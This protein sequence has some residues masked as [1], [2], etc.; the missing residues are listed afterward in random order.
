[1]LSYCCDWVLLVYWH[2]DWLISFSVLSAAWLVWLIFQFFV[3]WKDMMEWMQKAE[4]LLDADTSVSNDHATIKAQIIKHRVRSHE[5]LKN[6]WERWHLILCNFSTAI[7]PT[8]YVSPKH[9]F[10]L[11]KY[12]LKV[13]LSH[14]IVLLNRN[15]REVSELSSLSTMV[16]I[17][18]AAPWKTRAPNQTD[19]KLK[20]NLVPWRPSGTPF[21]PSL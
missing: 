18:W 17:E 2:F 7:P 19:Q 10:D 12:V 14:H 3:M 5:H 11:S 1:M 20:R 21:V 4:T 15:S 6:N 9:Y 16:W 13:L 8:W